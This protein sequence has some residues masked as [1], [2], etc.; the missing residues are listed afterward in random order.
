MMEDNQ[1]ALLLQIIEP[2]LDQFGKL[3]VVGDMRG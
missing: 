1:A 2:P 3:I